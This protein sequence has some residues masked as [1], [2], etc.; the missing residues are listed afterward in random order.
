MHNHAIK[1]IKF[2]KKV[3]LFTKLANLAVFLWTKKSA[4]YF[5]LYFICRKWL[6]SHDFQ[7]TLCSKA[8]V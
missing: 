4:L 7:G 5:R 6:M 1:S 2:F 3:G 8:Y